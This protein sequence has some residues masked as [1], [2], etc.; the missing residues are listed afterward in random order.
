MGILQKIYP[1]KL[2]QNR[3]GPHKISLPSRKEIQKYC[4]SHNELIN[5][6]FQK[7]YG[8]QGIPNW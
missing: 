3:K 6:K 7:I 1:N 8:Y 4:V 2:P 5:D